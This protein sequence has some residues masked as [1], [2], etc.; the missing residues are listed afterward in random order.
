MR[1]ECNCK[2]PLLSVFSFSLACSVDRALRQHISTLQQRS[3]PTH[4]LLRWQDLGAY[5]TIGTVQIWNRGDCCQGR[6]G[7]FQ[8]LV[9]SSPGPSAGTLAST[10]LTFNQVCYAQT[11]TTV[12]NPVGT[13]ACTSAM[14]GRYVTVQQTYNPIDSSYSMNL[15]AILVF[16]AVNVAYNQPTSSCGVYNNFTVDSDTVLVGYQTSV[17]A[18]AGCPNGAYYNSPNNAGMPWVTIVRTSRNINLCL[19]SMPANFC[20]K[21]LN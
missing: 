4:C 19:A 18:A 15:C 3:A 12:V 21:A 14:Y 16:Q 8:I 17:A 20:C 6:L 9:G 5:Y 7:Q 1:F 10:P 13:F 2:A 11:T